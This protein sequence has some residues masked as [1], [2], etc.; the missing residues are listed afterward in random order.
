MKN[1]IIILLLLAS[2]SCQN[3]EEIPNIEI[4]KKDKIILA[5]GDSLTAWLGLPLEDAYPGQLQELLAKNGYS[6]EVIN[7]WVSGDTSENVLE[8]VDLYLN[9][10]ARIPEIAILVIGA[11]DGM[12]GQNLEDLEE[13]INK[14]I[15]KLKEK[16]IKI[17]LG[18]MK[19]PPNLWLF[20]ANDF[21][22]IYKRVAEKQ[23]IYLIDFF[24]EWVAGSRSLNLDDGIHPSKE[25][26]EIIVQNVFDFLVNNKLVKN[27]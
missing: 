15:E 23:D 11:N 22:K 16:N 27:D 2:I 1:L 17:V 13:N 14:I 24:L 12:R 25:G 4:Q 19:I 5:L 3:K 8:R 20:Y 26:Y 10:T 6:Y 9:D 7:A 21:F 18:W